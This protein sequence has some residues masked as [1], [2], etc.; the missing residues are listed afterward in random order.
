MARSSKSATYN[1]GS[2]A[3][4]RAVNPIKDVGIG[5]F[6]SQAY[7]MTRY[8][9]YTERDWRMASDLVI[10]N[11]QG[12]RW[13]EL[14]TWMISSSA[15]VQTLIERRIAPILS[16]RYAI[17]DEDG[18]INEELTKSLSEEWF[19]GVVETIMMAT[20]QGYSAGVFD[21]QKNECVRYPLSLIDPFNDSLKKTPYYLAGSDKFADYA[22]LVYAKRSTQYQTIL[23]LFQPMAKEYIG[24]AIQL[25]NWLASGTRQSYPM[26]IVGYN[27]RSTEQQERI[28]P[29]TNQTEYVEVNT[30]KDWARYIADNID[31]TTA[32][33]IPFQ[34]SDADGKPQYSIEVKQSEHHSS[35]NAYKTF[36]D[37]ID[38]AEQR[39]ITL[40]LG[41][42]L[43]MTEG[44]SRSLG[45]V[46][47]RI[48]NQYIEKDI[49]WVLEQLNNMLIKKLNVPD[50]LKFVADTTNQLSIEDAKVIS[51]LMKENGKKLTKDFFT[52]M[53]V[54]EVYYEEIQMPAVK[55]EKPK[56]KDDDIEQKE[57]EQNGFIQK[58]TDAILSAF[59]AEKKESEQIEVKDSVILRCHNLEDIV[60]EK[61]VVLPFGCHS[62]LPDSD[63]KK[64]YDTG[65]PLPIFLQTPIYNCYGKT[66]C[67]PL[68]CKSHTL[69]VSKDDSFVDAVPEKVPAA[70]TN[71]LQF[72]AAKNVTEQ[73]AVNQQIHEALFK[74]GK[75]VTYS[76]FKNSVNGVV[77]QFREDWLKTEYRTAVNSVA[78]AQQWA[79]IE[80]SKDLYPYWRYRTQ[81]DNSVRDTHRMLD[82]KIFSVSDA[83]GARI[84]P[85]ND[86]N[87]RCFAEQMSEA[88]AREL[89]GDIQSTTQTEALLQSD[90]AEEFR[91]NPSQRIMP[92]TGSYFTGI[93]SANDISFRKFDMK[94]SAEIAKGLPE[95]DVKQMDFPEISKML[96]SAKNTDGT[97]RIKSGLTGSDFKI[98][99]QLIKKLEMTGGVGANLLPETIMRPT[100][101]WSK[102]IDP[103]VQTSVEGAMISIF[104]NAI[105][106]V[107]FKDDEIEDAYI[108]RSADEVDNLRKGVLFCK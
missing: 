50:G 63:I 10:N 36:Y 19:K 83:A 67:A 102:W 84:F 51:S 23:G 41:S 101:M 26:T 37:Y 5:A 75:K 65:E 95:T 97:Y 92:N 78:M 104:A 28:N 64:M 12:Q 47:E 103:M 100:E 80:S 25:R 74:D 3:T 70:M 20:F 71:I 59:R 89:S 11:G 6:V 30:N 32:L 17:S 105:Y 98:S 76:E 55:I 81:R 24:I 40:V 106:V 18:V 54:P 2:S 107:K 49:E 31:P 108:A 44:N 29:L 8:Q 33:T 61:D 14:V 35:D 39:M 1:T 57:K 69:A 15:F 96:S 4:N 73:A 38:K 21:I 52:S 46:H 66:L 68:G 85:P 45:E 56:A 53:G 72:S 9:D 27:G 60:T 87:C 62:Y 22:N 13:D 90:V 82:G 77:K 99:K 93:K 48:T 16:I 79:A 42:T 88:A 91:V 58:M 7:P 43:T 94:P 34:F 86:W